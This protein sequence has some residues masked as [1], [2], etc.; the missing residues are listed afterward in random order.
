MSYLEKKHLATNQANSKLF[1]IAS[2]AGISK[3]FKAIA[4]P[5]TLLVISDK[6]SLEEISFYFTFFNLIAMQQLAELGV[7]H[8]LKLSIAHSIHIERDL[9][10]KKIKAYFCFS[11]VYFSGISAFILTC[12]GYAGILYY[13]S[14]SGQI[15]WFYPWIS[16][17]ISTSIVTLLTPISLL[18]EGLQ[19]QL[20][21]Y[22]AQA[23]SSIINPIMTCLFLYLNFGLYSISIGLILSSMAFYLMLLPSF[24]SLLKKIK[25]NDLTY[26]LK[27]VLVELWPL[28]SRVSLVWGLGFV[29]WNGFNL[30]AFKYLPPIDAGKIIFTFTLAKVGFSIAESITQSHMPL[31]SAELSQKKYH[32]TYKSFLNYKRLSLSTLIFGYSLFFIIKLLF[33]SFYVF[34]KV[35]DELITLQIFFFFI[36]LLLLTSYNNFIRCFKVEPFLKV[37]IYHSLLCPF[38]FY[39]SCLYLYQYSFIFCSLIILGSLVISKKITHNYINLCTAR[40]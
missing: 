12:V 6:L 34:E 40:F 26:K 22:K 16:L 20:Q 29:F 9:S 19:K 36:I 13:N 1:K 38:V 23:I 24:L 27:E 30:I 37:S 10:L 4:A 14:Y 17:V 8:V 11:I 25:N 18:L 15:D 35:T 28:L 39:L 5:I 32:S 7:G 31:Y 33:P 21:I 3:L 2:Y